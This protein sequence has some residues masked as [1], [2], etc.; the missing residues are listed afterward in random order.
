MEGEMPYFIQYE[1]ID[2]PS[3]DGYRYSYDFSDPEAGPGDE[4]PEESITFVFGKMGDQTFDDLAVDPGTSSDGLQNTFSFGEIY[5][6]S[7]GGV[8]VACGDVNAPG[9]TFDF[10][11][12]PTAPVPGELIEFNFRNIEFDGY[13]LDAGS[14]HTGGANFVMCDGSVRSDEG[15]DALAVDPTNPN[16][17]WPIGPTPAVQDDGLL[18]PY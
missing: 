12:E 18:L 7:V 1:G 11:T 8:T 2:P 5:Q 15:F 16:V 17:E 9:D 3:I 10:T 13:A 14:K 6:D 4:G